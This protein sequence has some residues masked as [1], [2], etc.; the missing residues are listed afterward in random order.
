MGSH[1]DIRLE[2]SRDWTHV[3][4]RDTRV[5]LAPDN[6]NASYAGT[7]SRSLIIARAFIAANAADSI[8]VR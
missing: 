2:R 1:S 7:P 6:R 4:R 5:L 8:S 3:F